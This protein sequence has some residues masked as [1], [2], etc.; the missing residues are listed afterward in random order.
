MIAHSQGLP[1][2]LPGG[3]ESLGS[4]P[5]GLVC[6]DSELAGWVTERSWFSISFQRRQVYK[7]CS[8]KLIAMCY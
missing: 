8:Q 2:L 5:E 4:T 3:G 6:S 1:N 7:I